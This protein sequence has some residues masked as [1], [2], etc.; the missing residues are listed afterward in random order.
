MSVQDP[1]PLPEANSIAGKAP[2]EKWPGRPDSERKGKVAS[3][4]NDDLE[5]KEFEAGGKMRKGG[6]SRLENKALAGLIRMLQAL[7]SR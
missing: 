6:A 4:N 2:V 1:P 7:G 5:A 3:D